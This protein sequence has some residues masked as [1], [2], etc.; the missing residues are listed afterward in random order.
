MGWRYLHKRVKHP[1]NDW[2]KPML[3]LEDHAKA[4]AAIMT[5][6]GANP[7]IPADEALRIEAHLDAIVGCCNEMDEWVAAHTE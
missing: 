7:K 5:L 1:M 2:A 4:A 6:Y 3:S